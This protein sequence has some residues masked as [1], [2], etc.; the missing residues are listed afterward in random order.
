MKPWREIVNPHKDVLKGTFQQ[1]EFS[2]DLS[3]VYKGEAKEEYQDPV[4]FFDRTYITEGMR[5]LLS[6]VIKRLTGG[7]GDPVIEL[8]TNFGG[9][10]THSL[11]AVYH[12]ATRNVPVSKLLGIP[13]LLDDEEL[14][15]KTVPKAQCAVIDGNCLSPNEILYKDGNTAIHTLWGLLAWQLLGQEGY[16]MVANSDKS[17]TAPGKPIVIDLLRKAAPCVILLD[18]LV[19]FIR[20]FGN[21][22]DLSAGTFGSNISFI[23][24]LTESVKAVD[25]SI[26]LAS[27]P[28]SDIEAGGD[29]GVKALKTL[30]KNFGRIESI[31][32]PVATDEGFE[33]VRRRLFEKVH[34]EE[35]MNAVCEEYM[36]FYRAHK[37]DFPS[38]V[39]MEDYLDR[40]K[41]SY[42]IHP[43]VFDRLYKDWSTLEK[44]QSTRGVLQYMATVIYQL[45]NDN[46]QDALIMPGSIP[47]AKMSGQNS[48]YITKNWN[49]IVEDEID[50]DRSA[51]ARLDNSEVRFG[52]IQASRRIT[53]TIFLGSAPDESQEVTGRLRPVRGLRREQILLGCVVPKQSLSTY[54]DALTRLRN[55]LH[56]LFSNGT[57]FWFD[58]RPN[59]K[60]EMEYRK[61]KVD[62][63]TRDKKLRDFAKKIFVNDRYL[64]IYIFPNNDE[65]PEQDID[66]HGLQLVILPPHADFTY[67]SHNSKNLH[68]QI[69]RLL[70]KRGEQARSKRNRLIFIVPGAYAIVKQILDSCNT[71]LAWEE[72]QK[73]YKE[74]R[75]NLDSFQSREVNNEL[76][77]SRKRLENDFKACYTC[78]LVPKEKEGKQ[79]QIDFTLYKLETNSLNEPIVSRISRNLVKSDEIIENWNPDDLFELL[80]TYYFGKGKQTLTVETLWD[81]FCKYYF[82]PRLFSVNVLLETIADGVERRI[83]GYAASQ[84][85]DDFNSFKFGNRPMFVD[86]SGLIIAPECAFDFERKIQPT[87]MPVKPVVKKTPFPSSEPGGSTEREYTSFYASA[88]IDSVGGSQR[89]QE[90]LEE[91]VYQLNKQPGARVELLLTIS[92][93]S[94]TPFEKE[95]VRVVKENFKTLGLNNGGFDD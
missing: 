64:T 94:Q 27:L 45:W 1:S 78:I 82:Y 60:R 2:A 37:S 93:S 50:G 61:E 28:Q 70:E 62:D 79:N 9:G 25:K 26:L 16:D 77:L 6:T 54:D 32:K 55:Q 44:F 38:E 14:K 66:D 42:P 74:D 15:V 81:D 36:R 92:A 59:L 18:E 73:D 19:A 34:D 12:L 52:S 58:T 90:I 65:I 7:G 69:R 5:H 33:I 56:Y 85:G 87:G 43:E 20:Q 80:K 91:L 4:K 86:K 39:Q 57:Q 95:I 41:M 30:E 71:L 22:E 40:M 21:K 53:R 47:Q 13:S 68:E 72:I 31:W 67:D 83:F 63:Y 23:Q 51:P 48:K 35:S 84:T 17:G 24:T 46:D 3:T 88:S 75:I 8:Q 10:K 29:F 49:S 89:F 76:E 11:L